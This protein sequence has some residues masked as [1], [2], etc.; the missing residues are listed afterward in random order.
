MTALQ[1]IELYFKLPFKKVISKLHWK[2][3]RSIKSLSDECGVS[4]DTFQR[5]SKGFNIDL[6][7]LQ[8]AAKLTKNRG[9]RH[10]AFGLTKDNSEWANNSSRRMTKNN[11]A[12]DR[13]LAIKRAR[14]ISKLYKEKLLP[15]ELKMKDILDKA[16]IKYEVQ[17]PI[18]PYVIDFFIPDLNLCLEV[19][20]TSKWGKERRDA[21]SIKDRYLKRRSFRM[22]RVNKNWLSNMDRLADILKTNNIVG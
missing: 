5:L 21:A 17:K 16:F 9:E 1:K 10:W 13:K 6:R 14:T 12:N 2:E 8:D 18:G 4:R 20:S 15:Q 11:P 3:K 19:D 22:V 7:S